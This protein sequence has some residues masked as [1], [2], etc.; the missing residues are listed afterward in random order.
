MESLSRVIRKHL[1]EPSPINPYGSPDLAA[2][3]H[4]TPGDA[5]ARPPYKLYS[6]GSI[7]LAGF[8]G[9]FVAA[10]ATMA[11]NYVRV[12]RSTAAWIVVAGGAV[13]TVLLMA[14][15]FVLP[16][17]VPSSAYLLPQLLLIYFLAD[18]LQ[19]KILRR[20]RSQRGQTASAWGA[21]GIGL[22]SCVGIVA[23]IFAVIFLMPDPMGNAILLNDNNDDIYYSGD[24]TVEDAQKLGDLL[25]DEG[26]LGNEGA[27]VLIAKEFEMYTVSFVMQ[28]GRCLGR[29][30]DARLFSRPGRT[31]RGRRFR[32]SACRLV[33]RRRTRSAK[34][35]DHR[36]AGAGP[37]AAG[38]TQLLQSNGLLSCR[39]SAAVR[40][41]TLELVLGA[42]ECSRAIHPV[43]AAAGV[44]Q[45][46]ATPCFRTN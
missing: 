37:T 41:P 22:L 1:M 24:A 2:A 36:I 42:Y 10:A 26:F 31:G 11:L 30:G 38:P 25:T 45:V 23:V 46:Q 43:P 40:S 28:D 20:H 14:L 4:T 16:E 44:L 34:R 29:P 3:D 12:Q 15:V 39:R 21:A 19:G 5:A 9:S 6:V 17:S 35:A 33:G 27:T 7:V 13:A 8:L 32:P 18:Q